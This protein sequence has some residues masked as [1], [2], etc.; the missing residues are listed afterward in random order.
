MSFLTQAYLLDR[1]GPR[2]SMTELAHGAPGRARI[3]ASAPP[4]HRTA[5]DTT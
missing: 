2:L 1:Y 5:Q 4:R 3:A